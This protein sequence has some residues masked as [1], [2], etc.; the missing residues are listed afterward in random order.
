[1]RRARESAGAN[2]S[3]FAKRIGVPQSGISKIEA[4][5]ALPR[6]DVLVALRNELGIP[7]DELLGLPPLSTSRV[8]PVD[9]P[10]PVV[11]TFYKDRWKDLPFP[12]ETL[13]G[14]GR[15][16]PRQGW[17]VVLDS[18]AETL[19]PKKRRGRPPGSSK[20]KPRG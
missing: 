5:K 6:I 2:Q 12:P 15:E 4:G 17:K 11:L 19:V 10:L 7:L 3:A 1:M 20:T 18:L 14:D 13:A 9:A 16:P 8:P